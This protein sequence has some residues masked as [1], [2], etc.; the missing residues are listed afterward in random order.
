MSANYP[1]IYNVCN[2]CSFWDTLASIY[3]NKYKNCEFKLASA[4]F[5][6]P[7]RRACSTL[8]GAFVRQQ[9]PKPV[10]LP[11]IVPIT[12]IDDDELFFDKFNVANS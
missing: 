10:I 6:V 2:S 11:Q 8:M 5:L 4:L 1:N 3:L 7:N 9:G 12:E